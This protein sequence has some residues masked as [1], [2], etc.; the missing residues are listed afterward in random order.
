M[1]ISARGVAHL[2]YTHDPVLGNN[3]EDGDIRYVHSPGPPY[4]TWSNP[5][6]VNDDGLG[7]A[8]G[9][10]ALAVE[11]ETAHIIWLDH[12]IAR[13]NFFY[14]V[15]YARRSPTGSFSNNFRVTDASSISSMSAFGRGFIG[16]YIDLAA[17]RDR[18]YG[19]WVDRRNAAGPFVQNKDIFGGTVFPN[20]RG[21]PNLVCN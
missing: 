3:Q 7:R 11:G 16:E 2:V 6:T 14:D 19:I 12:R 1:E 4:Q 8:Q 13:A 9:F 5:I 15:Y 20:V 21:A 17:S 18:A 10:P